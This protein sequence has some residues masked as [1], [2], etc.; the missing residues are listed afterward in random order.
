MTQEARHIFVG[1]LADMP[2]PELLATIHRNHVPGVLEVQL[3]EFSKRIFILGGDIIFAS[4]TNR[5]ESLGDSLLASGQ[6]TVTQY[7]E[8]ALQLLA[9]PGKRHGQVLV[10]MG[11]LTE[12]EMRAAVL[13]QVQRIVWSLFDLSEGLVS[14]TLGEDRADEVYKLRIP[15]PRAVLHGCKTVADAKRLVARLGGKGSVFSRPPTP[16]HLGEFQLEA[17][18]EELL[19]LVNGRRTLFELCD[20]GPFSAGLNARVLYAFSC[21]GMIKK[22]KDSA[23]AIRVQVASTEPTS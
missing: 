7:R 20:Q 9:N 2:L 19:D 12:A 11:M 21:L 1:A 5:G 23:T 15:T 22:D 13:Q 10:E 17:G 18:E 3:A 4:S 8:S 16:E 6:I 14:F